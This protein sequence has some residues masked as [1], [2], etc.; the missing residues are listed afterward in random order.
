[1]LKKTGLYFGEMVAH[2]S[3]QL[4]I[5]LQITQQQIHNLFKQDLPETP[6]SKQTQKDRSPRYGLIFIFICKATLNNYWDYSF[7]NIYPILSQLSISI[8]SKALFQSISMIFRS[9]PTQ[10]LQLSSWFHLILSCTISS[11]SCY[12]VRINPESAVDS[13]GKE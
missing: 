4:K 12:L 5:D 1:M 6:I 13:N 8:D 3:R 7:L 10:L 11:A 9:I 2:M